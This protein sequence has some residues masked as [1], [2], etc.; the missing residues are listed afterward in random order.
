MFGRGYGQ[1]EHVPDGLVE[2]R[3]CPVTEGHRLVFVLQEVLHVA[4]L[5]VHC[6][7]VVHGHYSALF[8]PEGTSEA[9]MEC[10]NLLSDTESQRLNLRSWLNT[11]TRHKNYIRQ[12]T[13]MSAPRLNLSG[14]LSQQG[15]S[16]PV[17]YTAE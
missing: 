9:V 3:V 12:E 2:A 10:H 5:M 17:K 11:G 15:F 13:D 14:M 1:G 8:D 4:H 16:L 6:D 7:Q